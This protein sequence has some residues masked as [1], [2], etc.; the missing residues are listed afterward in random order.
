MAPRSV[1]TSIRSAAAVVGAAAS[2]AAGL[3]VS[4]TTGPSGVIGAASADPCPQVEVVFA[5]GRNERPGVGRVG[6][7]FVDALRAKTPLNVGVYA[8]NYPANIEIPQGANDISSRIQDMA[9]RCPD[10]RP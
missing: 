9:S 1:I 8:V 3:V 5:R 4:T 10:T 6:N 2:V 7:A